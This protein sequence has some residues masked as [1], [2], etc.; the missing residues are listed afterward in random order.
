[1]TIKI[2]FKNRQ[3]SIAFMKAFGMKHIAAALEEAELRENP[4][5]IPPVSQV[6]ILPEE[7]ADKSTK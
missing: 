5:P 1:M 3:E 4:D 2:K 7:P 6:R